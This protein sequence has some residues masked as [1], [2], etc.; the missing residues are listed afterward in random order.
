MDQQKAFDMVSH[1]WLALVLKRGNFGTNFIKWVTLLYEGATSKVV[2]NGA[3]SEAFELGRG[4]RQGDPL[5]M[6][7]YVLSLEP[8]LESIRQ[9]KDITGIDDTSGTT[10]KLLAFADDT[11]FFPNTQ[12]SIQKIT[13][14]FKNFGQCSGSKINLDKSKGMILGKGHRLARIEGVNW[15]D[16]LKI[17]GVTYRNSRDPV[18]KAV[19]G[20]VLGEVERDIEKFRFFSTSIFGRANIINT[21]IHPKLL[22]LAHVDTPPKKI[23]TQYNKLVRA[24]VFKDTLAKVKH[25]T[26]IQ[27]KLKGGVNLQDLEL[28]IQSLRLKNLIKFINKKIDNPIQHYYISKHLMKHIRY[29]NSRPHF[30]G[31]LPPYYKHTVDTYKKHNALI[32]INPNKIY[33]TLV[34]SQLE[35]LDRQIKRLGIGQPVGD[36]FKDLH[37]NPNFTHTQKNIFYRLLFSLTPTGYGRNIYCRFCNTHTE[38]EEHIYYTCTFLN[39]IK[40]NLIKLLRQP[41]NTDRELYRLIFLGITTPN[42]GKDIKHYRQTLAQLYRDTIWEGRVDASL[43]RRNLTANALSEHFL[44]KTKQYIQT[45]VSITTLEKL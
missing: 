18:D 24:F 12:L 11:N 16:R 29:D 23:L 25:S 3:L 27:E 31:T 4:V 15:V 5:S 22:Y 6:I 20:E 45:K 10:Q 28:K 44:A 37:T 35:P 8:L 33:S 26:L 30:F 32:D 14:H 38:S 41:I 9:D 36:I 21:L 34:T 7:L 17:F 43:N 40:V 2:V 13:D 19:W 39:K 1:E 42:S